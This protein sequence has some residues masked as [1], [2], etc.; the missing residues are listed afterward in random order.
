MDELKAS[1]DGKLKNVIE[2]EQTSGQART[3][4]VVLWLERVRSVE[5]EY[6]SFE[7]EFRSMCTCKDECYL[8]CSLSSEIGRKAAQLHKKA[9]DVNMESGR[10][11]KLVE[12]IPGS[13]TIGTDSSLQSALGKLRRF[14]FRTEKASIIGVCG[15]GGI[16]KTTLLKRFRDE[17]LHRPRDF[18]KIIFV[19]VSSDPSTSRIQRE[20]AEMLSLPIE[21]DENI[22]DMAKKIHKVLNNVKFALLLDDVWDGPNLL[23]IL[24]S[25]GVPHPDMA[26]KCKLILTTR[27]EKTCNQMGAG[28]HKVRVGLL[29]QEESL[30]LFELNVGKSII[31]SHAQIPSLAEAITKKCGGLPLA[32]IVIGRA[33]A[34]KTTI[35][36][37]EHTVSSLKELRIGKIDGMENE[38]F[39]HLRFSYDSLPSATI[40]ECFLYCCLYPEDWNINNDELVDYW[41]GEGFFNDECGDDLH[42]ARGDGHDIIGKLKVAHLL[43]TGASDDEVKMHDVIRDMALW[44][45][46]KRENKFLVR[47]KVGLRE[48]PKTRDWSGTSRISLMHNEI[49]KLPDANFDCPNLSTLL[50]KHNRFLCEVPGGFFPSMTNLRVLDMS[51]TRITSLPKELGGLKRLRN[52]Y[53]CHTNH[54]ESIPKEAISGLSE[55]QMLSLC[56]TEYSIGSGHTYTLNAF[57]GFEVCLQDLEALDELK[58]LQLELK[59]A[60]SY[61]WFFGSIKLR[62]SARVLIFRACNGLR[63][64]D[65]SSASWNMNHLRE[66][67]IKGCDELLE[68][69]FSGGECGHPVF[70]KLER[71]LLSN[72]PDLETIRAG[73]QNALE[74]LRYL[75]MSG[76]GSLKH[77]R[78]IWHFNCLEEITIMGFEEMENLIDG[79]DE[80]SPP[81]LPRLKLILLIRLPKLKS[82]CLHPLALPSLQTLEVYGCPELKRLSHVLSDSGNLK[83]IKGEQQWWDQLEWDDE[84]IKLKFLNQF[85]SY[86]FDG[87][88]LRLVKILAQ[89]EEE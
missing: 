88:V 38:L 64:M 80:V 2:L 10:L 63:T 69:I 82:I 28:D 40:K 53:L 58:E 25:I 19:V 51:Y 18:K 83:V 24:E 45:A 29:N 22:S 54:L 65:F 4:Q 75:K 6:E 7:A 78:W 16:G 33:M 34:S 89:R 73:A 49:E 67:T 76:C 5:E 30:V 57:N 85:L 46:Y 48:S 35:Q 31:N 87:L 59:S 79:D 66:L 9:Q 86:G 68:L 8:N 70:P 47:A 43:E 81:F 72:L 36:E 41:V 37:W 11:E 52:L 62:S 50:L 14:C 17:L 77:I 32:L 21:R 60:D 23:N 71:L 61:R 20:I 44:I 55:L 12:A 1:R 26:N 27:D 84:L 13:S 15:M 39:S 74:N 3:N 42:K 56:E